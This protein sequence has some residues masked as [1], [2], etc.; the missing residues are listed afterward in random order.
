MNVDLIIESKWIAP[1]IPEQ[2]LLTDYAVVIK[3]KKI[4]A[5]CPQKDL[6][7]QYVASNSIQL[8]EHI[9]MP[10]LINAHG[11]APMTLLRGMAD[12]MPLDDWLNTRIWPLEEKFVNHEFVESGA[13]LAIAEMILSGTTSFADMYFYPGQVAKAAIRSNMRVQLAS[14]ILD[15]PTVWAKSSEEYIAKATRLHDQYRNSE[16][17]STAFGPHAPYT[18]SD[19]PLTKIGMLA[20][21]LDVPIHMHIHETAQEVSD[22]IEKFGCRPLTRLHKIGFVNPRLNCVHAT[23]LTQ[24]EI[25]MLSESGSSVVHCPASNMKLASGICDV[26]KLIFCN[27]NVCLGTDGAASN[28]ELDLLK[29][30]R[31]ASLLA[32]IQSRTASSLPAYKTLEMM[33]INGA[34]ALGLD[35][36]IGSLEPGKLADITAISLNAPNTLPINNP[37]SHVIYSV[38]SSQVSHVWVGGR[39]ILHERQ[40]QTVDLN[41]IQTISSRWQKRIQRGIT[42]QT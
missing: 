30:A 42:S 6:A 1:I 39:N 17:V 36:F 18:I 41:K 23:Q 2:S 24:D 14:P 28:N 37:L 15:F 32:K 26:S 35:K 8:S 31:L 13:E 33:T 21:E 38:N 5:V 12:D 4:V 22:S 19:A 40:L 9:L 34:K 10:G 16:L 27:T 3:D 11:H 25:A 20:E 29:E 7:S